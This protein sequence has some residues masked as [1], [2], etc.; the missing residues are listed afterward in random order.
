MDPDAAAPAITAADGD[1]P[2]SAAEEEG[3][4]E[5]EGKGEEE[6]NSNS[7]ARDAVSETEN[8]DPDYFTLE[9]VSGGN[10]LAIQVKSLKSFDI[11]YPKTTFIR[12][13]GY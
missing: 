1:D 10:G 13:G 8:T 12:G 11:G 5:E 4:E 7:N 2:A 3:K 9:D 6:D